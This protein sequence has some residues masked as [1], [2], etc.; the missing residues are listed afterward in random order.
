MSVMEKAKELAE[1]IKADEIMQEYNAAR[2]AYEGSVELQTK[3]TEYNAQRSIMGQEFSRDVEAQSPELLRMV[4]ERM[5]VLAREIAAL[6]EYKNFSAAQ[7]RVTD[8]MNKVNGEIQ[9][10]VFGI[11]PSM[12]ENCTHDCST[13]HANC[14]S[15]H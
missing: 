8:M 4:R 13:C 1:A 5:D 3:M 7:L 15:K 14:S 9:R 11:E 2:A 12:D 6:E 10:I